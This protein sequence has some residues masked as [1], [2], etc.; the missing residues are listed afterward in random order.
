MLPLPPPPLLLLLL[1]MLLILLTLL[2]IPLT[3]LLMLLTLLLILLTLLLILLT[4]L[5]VLPMLLPFERHNVTRAGACAAS[6]SSRKNRTR[7]DHQ[8]A[9]ALSLPVMPQ[10]YTYDVMPPSRELSSPTSAG[11]G[12][13]R[14]QERGSGRSSR[15]VH[16][17]HRSRGGGS[18]AHSPAI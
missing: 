1:L 13:R 18:V 8:H 11:L 4:L 7:A 16:R 15:S 6:S 10:K 2:L 9:G 3:L 5:L 12:S 17:S 14:Q